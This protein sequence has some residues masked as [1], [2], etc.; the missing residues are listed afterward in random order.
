[1]EEIVLME[2]VIASLDLK[3]NSANLKLASMIALVTVFVKITHVSARKIIS[4]STAQ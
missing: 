3:V 2:H 4:E 1:M